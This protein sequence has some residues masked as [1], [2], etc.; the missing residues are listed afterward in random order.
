MATI[1]PANLK[2]KVDR[3]EKT[4]TI[5]D[6]EIYN[7]PQEIFLEQLQETNVRWKVDSEETN[8]RQRSFGIEWNVKSF[9]LWERLFQSAAA[10]HLW[11]LFFVVVVGCSFA[12]LNNLVAMW[13]LGLA[14]MLTS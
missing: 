5:C 1:F 13:A 12:I 7:K 8:L 3:A 10:Q 9:L 6:L 14:F 2:K 4:R 11:E